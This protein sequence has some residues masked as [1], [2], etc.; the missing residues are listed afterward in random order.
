[1]GV[2]FPVVVPMARPAL[3][4]GIALALLETLNDIGASEF[5][6]I[7]TLTVTVYTTWVTRSDLAGAAQVAC[8][9]LAFVILVLSLEYY[10]CK[11]QRYGVS[12]SMQGIVS[13]R[14]YGWRAWGAFTFT[15][16]PVAFGFLLLALF[17]LWESYKRLP[18]MHPYLI[19]YSPA[20][21]KFSFP[22][23][24]SYHCQSVC[25]LVCS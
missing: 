14:L 15:I 22:R 10:G 13:K 2:F 5:L 7:N 17:L 3:A 20:F 24:D 19:Q 12:R 21:A 6:G 1:M 18:H 8:I 25:C 4:V 16:L 9:R 11:S 23:F